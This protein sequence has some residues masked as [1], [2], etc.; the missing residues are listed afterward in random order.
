MGGGGKDRL[1]GGFGSDT[2]VGG[3][4]QDSFVFRT[5]PGKSNVDRLTDFNPRDDLI[6]LDHLIFKKLGGA[7]FDMPVGL[8]ADAFHVG[9]RAADR[10][11]RIL[12]DKGNGEL[13]YDA[14]GSGSSKAIKFAQLSPDLALTAKDFLVI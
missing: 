3:Q 2:L 1:E 6:R 4:G 10:E 5:H 12:Y 11:D 7:A 9:T 8:R 14:D 13:W